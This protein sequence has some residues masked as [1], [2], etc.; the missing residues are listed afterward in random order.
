MP[1]MVAAEEQH[2]PDG[3]ND[4]ESNNRSFTHS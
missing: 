3:R 1:Q 4:G 2:D